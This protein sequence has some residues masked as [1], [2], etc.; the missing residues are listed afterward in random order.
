MILYNSA[1]KNKT[2]YYDNIEKTSSFEQDNN[3]IFCNDIINLGL[4]DRYTKC[5]FLYSEPP[6]PHGFKV[7]EKRAEKQANRTYDD[8][9]SGLNKIIIKNKK[10]LFLVM[11]KI[12]LKKVIKP[13]Q[14][15]KINLSIHNSLEN[16]AILNYDIK[17]D[18]KSTDNLMNYFANRFVC[19]GDFCCGYGRNVMQFIESGGKNFVASDIDAKC[20]TVLKKRMMGEL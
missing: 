14:V 11:G 9:V 20:I 4:T 15:L 12:L 7:F 3:F 13:N 10:P 18:I 1:I 8:F 2:K 5:D 19:M 6:Y 16:L 17:E